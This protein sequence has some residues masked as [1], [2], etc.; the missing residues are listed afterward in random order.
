MKFGYPNHPRREVVEE[1]KWAAANGFDFVDMSLEPD[2]ADPSRIDPDAVR[3]ALEGHGLDVLGH[4]AWYLPIGSP[5]AEMRAAAVAVARRHLPVFLKCGAKV[6][7]V[8]ANWPAHLFTEEEGLSWQ[9]ES[10]RLISGAAAELGMRIMYEPIGT[11]NDH[12][13]NV[14]RLLDAAPALLCHLDTGHCNLHG[15]VPEQMIRFMGDRLFHLH[16]HDNHG[17]WDHHLPPGT[18]RINWAEVFKALR[19]VKYDRTMTIEVF[20]HDREYVLLALRR[21]KEMW[22]QSAGQGRR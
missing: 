13:A 19:A 15:R 22:E 3:G 12:A 16:V 8:H 9:V 4:M 20:S 6:V 21:V 14:R 1:V 10:L 7:T 11:V 2:V 18:G 17:D 5:M